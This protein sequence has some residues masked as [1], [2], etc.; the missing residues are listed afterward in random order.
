M[1]GKWHYNNL[2]IYSYIA[3]SFTKLLYIQSLHRDRVCRDFD[4]AV[5]FRMAGL[6]G[7]KFCRLLVIVLCIMPCMVVDSQSTTLNPCIAALDLEDGGT[8][9]EG[10]YTFVTPSARAAQG[11][12]L[13]FLCCLYSS[14]SGLSIPFWRFNPITNRDSFVEGPPL[15]LADLNGHTLI[16]HTLN[17][18]AT[19]HINNTEVM[20][21]SSSGSMRFNSMTRIIVLGKSIIPLHV[22]GAILFS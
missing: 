4:G 9:E 19:S 22:Y 13:Y 5:N 15:T 11:T 8:A 14:A 3:G 10:I 12:E 6:K 2:Y 1:F 20:C 21:K 18:T 17:V 16:S 7:K